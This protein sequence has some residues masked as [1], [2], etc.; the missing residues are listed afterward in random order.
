VQFLPEEWS[1]IGNSGINASTN[2]LETSDAVDLVFCASSVEKFRINNTT[3]QLL[4]NNSGRASQPIYSFNGNANTGI[5]RPGTNHLGFSTNGSEWMSLSSA[6]FLGLNQTT[7]TQSLEVRNGNILLS[8]SGTAGQLQFQAQ[9]SVLL[10]LSKP[11]HSMQISIYILPTQQSPCA[12]L[13]LVN[14]GSGNL[15][16]NIPSLGNSFA[17]SRDNFEDFVFNA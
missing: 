1:T 17:Y 16:C 12:N 14:D 13:A 4:A 7:P 3:N 5:F 10:P 15:S 11:L 8:N 2:F 6:G 9:G